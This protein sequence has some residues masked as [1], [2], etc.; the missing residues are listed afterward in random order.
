MMSDPQEAMDV[1]Q[2]TFVRAIET[3]FEVRS[4]PEALAWLY[5]TATQRC[6]WLLRNRRSRSHLRVVHHQALEGLRR[7]SPE[8]SA[9]DREIVNRV[10]AQVDERTGEIALLTWVQGLSNERVA[11]ICEVSVRTVGRARADF[12]ARVRALTEEAG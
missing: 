4:R 12:E 7:P 3:G 10:L 5:R 9:A 2:W 11:E 8:A 6:L 1:T